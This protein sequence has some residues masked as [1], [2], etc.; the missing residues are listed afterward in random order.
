MQGLSDN[1]SCASRALGV[2]AAHCTVVSNR[3]SL[4]TTPLATETLATQYQR[5]YTIRCPL[6]VPKHSPV[7]LFRA[8]LPDVSAAA[9]LETYARRAGTPYAR[10]L[11][12]SHR[13]SGLMLANVALPISAINILSGRESGPSRLAVQEELVSVDYA[14]ER[15][16]SVLSSQHPVVRGSLECYAAMGSSCAGE[17]S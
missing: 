9:Q 12:S 7:F 13:V 10:H 15:R 5:S 1:V 17:L 3:I 6:C 14:I 11:E 8:A 4:F 2:K 16:A